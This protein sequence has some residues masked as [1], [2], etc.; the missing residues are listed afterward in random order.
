MEYA[1]SLESKGY[2]L[3]VRTEETPTRFIVRIGEE[4]PDK[5]TVVSWYLVNKADGHVSE[6]DM[7]KG[8]PPRD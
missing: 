8:E 7:S 6:W 4:R 3:Y 1:K 5:V 2:A